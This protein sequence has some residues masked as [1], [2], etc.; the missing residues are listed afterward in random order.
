MGW[1]NYDK[2]SN[3][4]L[5]LFNGDTMNVVTRRDR[6][7]S[8]IRES[9]RIIIDSGYVAKELKLSTKEAASLLREYTEHP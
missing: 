4:N 8:L 6:I 1:D 7:E 3:G 5:S 2:K 9:P